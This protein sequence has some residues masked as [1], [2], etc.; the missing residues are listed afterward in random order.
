MI[1]KS[2]ILKLRQESG[3]GMVECQKALE[4]SNGNMEE[5][6]EILRKKGTLK[7]AK[8]AER[9]TKEGLVAL[10]INDDKTKGSMI[11]VYCETDF[12]SRNENFINL[13][14][15]LVEKTFNGESATN[16][17]ENRK[18]DLVMKIGENLQFGE[19]GTIE[20]TLV[21]GYLHSNHK[22]GVL[23]SF[24]KN[25]DA[26]L[27][28]G[29]AMHIAAMQPKYLNSSEVPTEVLDKEKEIYTEQLKAE[30][31]PEAIIEKIM[32][33]KINK[34]YEDICLL[35]QK[36][37]KDDSKSIQEIIGDAKING[38]LLFKI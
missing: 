8:K 31:K 15:E 25:I 10:K 7:A 23:I 27:A 17:F 20:G 24:D 36:Y 3:A 35:N 38:Y 5:A 9:A 34:F 11:K 37:V 26:N 30:G 16:D 28:S 32:G 14:N 4:E 21:V 19:E 33:G 22:N 2:L 13:V 6:I 29:I 12:V 1:D 18:S